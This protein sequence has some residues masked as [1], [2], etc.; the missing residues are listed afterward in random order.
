MIC[1]FKHY[2]YQRWHKNLL[3]FVLPICVAGAVASNAFSQSANSQ[4]DQDNE[5]TKALE[6]II[7]TGS[8]IRGT[9]E[10]SP[11]P[12]NV[13]SRE[14]LDAIGNPNIQE[15]LRSLGPSSGIDGETN[16]FQ[17]NGVEGLGNVNLRGLG[18]GRTLVLLNGKRLVKAG[19]TI[20]ENGQQFTNTNIIPTI[21]LGR[22]EVLLDGASATYGSDAIAG[23]VNFFTRSDFRGLEVSAGYKHI[24]QSDPD[25]EFGV[26]YGFGTDKLD[27]VA[28][29]GY[30]KRGE[31]E[32]RDLDWAVANVEFNQLSTTG[33]PNPSAFLLKND[34]GATVGF[35]TTPTPECEAVGGAVVEATIARALYNGGNTCR[36]RYTEFDN[37][38]EEETH[39]QAFIE[40]TY[41]INDN[42][43]LKGEFLYA[44]D[45]VPAWNTSPSYPPQ[46]LFDNDRFVGVGMPHYDD[47]IARNPGYFTSA[48]TGAQVL[49]RAYG[50]S[51]PAQSGERKHETW[52]AQIS[53]DGSFLAAF[54]EN[55]TYFNLDIAYGA[56]SAYRN[57]N[58][59]RVDRF[60]WAYRGLGGPECSQANGTPG[61]GNL[62]TG[63]CY[64]YN[65]FTTGYAESLAPGATNPPPGTAGADDA[66]HTDPEQLLNDPVLYDWLFEG[67]AQD[68]NTRLFVADFVLSGEGPAIGEDNNI[69]WAAG[70]QFRS[71]SYEVDPNDVSDLSITPCPYGLT[72]AGETYNTETEIANGNL[73]ANDVARD[74]IYTC[75]GNGAFHFLAGVN[76]FDETQSTI[77]VFGE[78]SLTLIEN[79]DIQLALRYENYFDIGGT[80]DPKIAARWQILPQL[81]LRGSIGTSFRAPTL[82]QLNGRNTTLS[83]VA[84]TTSFKAIDIV[85]NPDLEPEDATNFNLG[86]IFQPIDNL[87]LTVDFWQFD[88]RKAIVRDSFNAIIATCFSTTADS[89]LRDQ[90]C[91]RITFQGGDASVAGNVERVSTDYIN[92]PD[93]TT[94]GID[95]RLDFDI[96][97][98]VGLFSIGTSGTYILKFD[99]GASTYTAPFDA[100]GL[101][102]STTSFARPLPQ[103]KGKLYG[104]WS[105]NDIHNVRAELNLV[106]SY[107]D[108]RRI[109][110]TAANGRA[111]ESDNGEIRTADA[112]TGEATGDLITTLD[113]VIDGWVSV[114]LHYNVM[115]LNK[116]LRLNASVYNLL[117]RSPPF[118]ALDLSYD[119]YT[120]NPFGRIIKV[121]I[122]YNFDGIGF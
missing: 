14:D 1:Y 19:F 85:G 43:K 15:I 4:A 82:N 9:P 25:F 39:W 112:T 105:I 67:L 42:W 13:T 86:L 83:F 95:Y 11:S 81:A 23:V 48:A 66:L 57:T 10:D 34:A 104:S 115:F 49:G 44:V 36:F 6:E 26:I 5:S 113:R 2:S 27:V 120:H 80:I 70:L 33:I 55:P 60:A 97:S 102:N 122:Q 106:S 50:V 118:A 46:S 3:R 77:A 75:E 119:S 52:Q 28:S 93:I 108:T 68:N 73:A 40:G 71:D 103:F 56:S 117:D 72:G 94:S 107:E 116:N 109:A 31:L 79:L 29:F 32:V 90:A 61:S 59:V 18:A 98:D 76:A 41:E 101:L 110:P 114:D 84:A 20:G 99:V 54:L 92:G 30:E 47:F 22:V 96:P 21:A 16:Q 69:G 78:V 91:A 12:V 38:K 65:P 87:N 35:A 58:D 45:D 121:G 63:D 89:V 100:V 24:D 7:V 37:I 64:Y 88:L 111:T 62:D 74:F 17:S 8:Y 53:L 51:G